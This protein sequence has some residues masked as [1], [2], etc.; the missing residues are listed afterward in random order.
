[1]CGIA[2]FISISKIWDKSDLIRMT[3]SLSHRGPDAEGF[4]FNNGIGLGHK[5]LSIIDLSATANQPMNSICGN[6]IIIYNG[7]L[8]NYKEIAKNLNVE[9]RS[10]SDTEVVLEAFK[11]WGY[12]CLDFF[13]GMFAF[14]IF[15]LSNRR[16]FIARDRMGIK[17]LFYFFNGKDFAFASELKALKKLRKNIGFDVNNTAIQ[18][19]LHLGYIPHPN[20]IYKQV[21]KFPAGSYAAIDQSKMDIKTYWSPLNEIKKD[22]I[23]IDINEATHEF[24]GLLND[25]VKIRLMSDV[26]FGTFLSGG[27]DSSLV[28]A[29]AQKNSTRPINTFTIGFEEEAFNEAPAARKISNH[30]NTRHHEMIFTEKDAIKLVPEIIDV[31]DEP[32]AD[33]SALPTMLLAKFASQHVSMTLAGDGGDEL[34][35]GYGFYRWADR[36]SKPQIY[37]LRHVIAAILKFGNMRMKRAANVFQIPDGSSFFSHIFSQEQYYFDARLIKKLL[38]STFNDDFL[39]PAENLDI[40]QHLKKSEQQAIFDLLYYLPDEL[41]IKTDR[42]TMKFGLETRVPVLDHRL[43]SFALNLPFH[44]KYDQ[45]H[46]K[47]LLKKILYKYIP[48]QFYSAPKHGFS[49]PL[50]KWL[51]SDLRFFMETYLHRKVVVQA[52]VVKY[53]EVEKIKKEFLKGKTYLYNKIWNLIL[54]HQFIENNRNEF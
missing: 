21:L 37:L 3:Q 14:A 32:Y 34:F 48:A 53:H 13:N 18:Q 17:P 26:P 40:P 24:E 19:F 42:S 5:R 44:L 29:L 27:I 15:D 36:M 4:Y 52:G 41:L 6:Y 46:S 31:F 22:K 49:V 2:G 28:T 38:C 10:N 39:I 25:A 43:V 1:M 23:K 33:S 54:L 7:E 11:K 35:Q 45:N 12:K 9:L 50:A 20:T 30:L 51:K 16:L 8:Y 47:I